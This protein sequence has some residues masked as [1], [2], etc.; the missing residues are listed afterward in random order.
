MA[1]CQ[2]DFY[3]PVGVCRSSAW[4]GSALHSILLSFLRGEQQRCKLPSLLRETKRRFR[5]TGVQ[6]GRKAERA[7]VGGLVRLCDFG[8]LS[9]RRGVKAVHIL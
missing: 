3:A 8:T 6:A 4:E 5:W 2:V 1:K 7:G 9:W